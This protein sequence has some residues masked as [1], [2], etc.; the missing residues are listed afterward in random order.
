MNGH[1]LNLVHGCVAGN[2]SSRESHAP[3]SHRLDDGGQGRERVDGG[4]CA[5]GSETAN[6]DGIAVKISFFLTIY[7]TWLRAMS[8]YEQREQILLAAKISLIKFQ[9]RHLM[10]SSL[11][12]VIMKAIIHSH[13]H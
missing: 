9:I 8:P 12:T 1:W 3:P 13:I 6:N 2:I 4:D 11:S 5:D 10:R 7:R